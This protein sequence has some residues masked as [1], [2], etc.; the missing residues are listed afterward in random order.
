MPPQQ[1]R[2]TGPGAT[3]KAGAAST[4][5]YMHTRGKAYFSYEVPGTCISRKSI[6]RVLPLLHLAPGTHAH[7]SPESRVLVVGLRNRYVQLYHKVIGDLTCYGLK[8]TSCTCAVAMTNSP[9][10]HSTSPETCQVPSSLV[11]CDR[12]T[13]SS[14]YRQA[15][16]AYESTA[17][18]VPQDTVACLY[19]LNRTKTPC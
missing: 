12:A 17:S 18:G 9:H 7:M 14:L 15:L 6:R 5:P 8:P 13:P 16:S 11:V 10:Q 4:N 1:V 19:K 3:Q 2:G